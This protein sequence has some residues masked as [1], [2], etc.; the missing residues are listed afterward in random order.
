MNLSKHLAAI[1][2]GIEIQIML[3]ILQ[4][5]VYKIYTHSDSKEHESNL[6]IVD[7]KVDTSSN[8]KSIKIMTVIKRKCLKNQPIK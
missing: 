6:L 5:L 1:K 2:Q 4:N 7:Y 8:S 3:M